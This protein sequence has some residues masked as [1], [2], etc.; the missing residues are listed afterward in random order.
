MIVILIVI[1]IMTGH[2]CA[3]I[4]TPP[5]AGGVGLV[6]SKGGQLQSQFSRKQSGRAA[7]YS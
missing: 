1:V 4:S 3:V 5:C 7:S 6:C 2:H